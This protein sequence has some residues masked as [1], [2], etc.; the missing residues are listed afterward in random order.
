MTWSDK[1]GDIPGSEVM[2]DLMTV[3]E[4]YSAARKSRRV[5]EDTNLIACID[6]NAEQILRVP[7]RL[8]YNFSL[9]GLEGFSS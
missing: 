3:G 8:L 7:R 9:V 1:Y 5:I 4:W 6:Q 2:R